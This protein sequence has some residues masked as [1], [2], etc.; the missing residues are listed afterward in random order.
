[1]ET[2]PSTPSYAN[3]MTSDSLESLSHLA[4]QNFGSTDEVTTAILTTISD[5]LG[6]RTSWVSHANE[7]AGRLDI[8]GAHNKPGGCDVQPNTSAP[9][10]NTF[11]TLAMS[12]ADK[13][14]LVIED[15]RNN[16]GFA[17]TVAARTFPNIGAYI[18]V[19]ICLSDGTTYGTLCASDPEPH[20]ISDDQT[21]LLSVLSRMLATHFER[22]REID[23]R[24]SAEDRFTAFM[25][26]SPLAAYMKDDEGRY[27]YINTPFERAFNLERSWLIGKTDQD[28]LDEATAAAVRENDQQV[29]A[30]RHSHQ[31][32]ETVHQPDG[33]DRFYFSYKFPVVDSS[34]QTFVGGASADITERRARELERAYLAAIVN[35]SS[36]AIYGRDLEGC[37][38]SWNPSAERLFGYTAEEMVGKSLDHLIPP[39]FPNDQAMLTER[40]RAGEHTQNYETRRQTKT[41]RVLDVALSLS[42]IRDASG[43][44]V[45]GST[46]ARDVTAHNLLLAER[47]RLMAELQE[48]M[49][50]A[51]NVQTHLLPR[52][53]PQLPGYEFAATCIPARDVGGDF[54]DWGGTADSVRITLGDVSGKGMPA[55]LLMAT[56]RAALRAATQLSVGEAVNAVNQALLEDLEQFDAFVTMFHVELSANG[57]LTYVDAGH[58]LALIVRADGTI[59]PLLSGQVPIGILP[60]ITYVTHH[61]HLAPDDTLVMYSDGLV[62]AR[63]GLLLE[64]TANFCSLCQPGTNALDTLERIVEAVDVHRALPDDLSVVLVHRQERLP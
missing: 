21:K 41:G 38:T 4:G 56:A 15:V 25:D 54:F 30:T 59:S 37:V 31:F 63:P 6:M 18:G 57:D 45:G 5:V 12:A 49:S 52:T 58:G 7:A 42:P 19:P 64:N 1:M 47:N 46:V 44:I 20:P 51:A 53:V 48:E 36:D 9:L 16:P 3:Q 40:L 39:G 61:D 33:T 60:D 24:R 10:P 62:D 43:V 29:L 14:P 28:W 32:V 26:H 2:G 22:D 35:N 55:A 8:I 50:R 11:C 17:Q 27:V 34:G 23:A 13:A